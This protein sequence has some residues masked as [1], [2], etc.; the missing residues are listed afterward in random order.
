[1]AFVATYRQSQTTT[2]RSEV[3]PNVQTPTTPLRGVVGLSNSPDYKS[4]LR[5]AS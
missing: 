2:T 1:M 3:M 5:I 4:T